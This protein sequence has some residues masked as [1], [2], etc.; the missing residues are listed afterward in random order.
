MKEEQKSM[1]LAG[2]KKLGGCAFVALL[3][4]GILIIG[5]STV[6][7]LRVV[8]GRWETTEGSVTTSVIET[9]NESNKASSSSRYD[10]YYLKFRYAFSVDG[11]HYEGRTVRYGADIELHGNT[12][13]SPLKAITSRYPK[14][15]EVTVHYKPSNPK[16]CVLEPEYDSG[17]TIRIVMGIL[18]I[19]F[20][21]LIRFLFSRMTSIG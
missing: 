4:L 10:T 16:I 18:L 6:Q 14:G 15:S 11:A 2:A 7:A 17:V 21:F 20:S 5:E 13:S 9:R 8:I 3:L 1:K 19:G 12:S